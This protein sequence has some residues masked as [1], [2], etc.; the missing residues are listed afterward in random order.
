M[1]TFLDTEASDLLK[2]ELPLDNPGQPWAV[3]ISAELTDINGNQLAFFSTPI[4]ADGRKITENARKVHGVSSAQAGQSGVGEVVALGMTIGFASESRY[5]VGFGLDFDRQLIQ[6]LLM[7][8]KKDTKLWT[9][10]GLEFIDVMKPAA[11]ICKIPSDHESGSYRWPNLDIAAEK[12]LGEPPR[13]GFHTAWGDLQL[14]KR[15]FFK[16]RE[17]NIIE[18]VT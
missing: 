18:I 9:R 1:I 7:R 12:I 14:A 15:I 11:H 16:L 6:S 2:R 13:T 5:V 8:R 4:R 3:S 10:P 17:Q